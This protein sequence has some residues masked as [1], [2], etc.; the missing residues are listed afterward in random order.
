MK[1]KGLYKNGQKVNEQKGQT[2]TWFFKTGL[3]KARGKSVNGVMEGRWIFNRES[4][5]LWQVGHFRHNMKH[6]EFV[7]YDKK[8][9]EEYRARFVDGKWVS[10]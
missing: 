2:L 3:M 8:G 1:T 10:K 6:G 7:R 5:Q 9:R 4:G